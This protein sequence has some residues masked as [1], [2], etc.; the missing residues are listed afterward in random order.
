MSGFLILWHH[1][2]GNW[3]PF[4]SIPRKFE[5][6]WNGRGNYGKS[7]FFGVGWNFLSVVPTWYC[8]YIYMYRCDVIKKTLVQ[9]I[10]H[11]L[12]WSFMTDMKLKHVPTLPHLHLRNRSILNK[13]FIKFFSQ[14]ST[15]INTS[16]VFLNTTSSC[17]R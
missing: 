10:V 9:F 12:E 17:V 3:E 5:S 7:S 4:L 2:K 1:L 15:L 14:C 16:C 6:T 11:H 8:V 13:P